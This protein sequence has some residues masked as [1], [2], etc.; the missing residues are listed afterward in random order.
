MMD[1][2]MSFSFPEGFHWG[3]ATAAHQ[4][5]GDNVNSDFWVMEHVEGTVF[6]EPS[7]H[8]CDHYHLYEQD[9]ARLADLGFNAY[10][11]SIEWARIEPEKGHFSTAQLD[12]YKR[13]IAVCRQ[14]G[15]TPFVTLQHFTSPRWLAALGGWERPSAADDFALY[16]EKVVQYLGEEVGAICTL[17]EIN[18]PLSMTLDRVLPGTDRIRSLDMV[19][20]AGAKLGSDCFSAFFFGDAVKTAATMMKAHRKAFDAIKNVQPDLPV[21]LTLALQELQFEP[22]GEEMWRERMR[23]VGDQFLEQC[24]GDDFIGVQT[25]TRT[26][27]DEN[28]KIP[29]PNDVEKTMMGYEYYPQ[30]LEQTIRWASKVSGCPVIVTENGIS[31]EDDDRRVAF[32]DRAL[33]SVQSCL[34]DGIDVEGYFYWSMLDNFEWMLGYRPKFGLIA[35]DRETQVRTVKPSAHHLGLIAST[36]RLK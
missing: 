11:F 19:K 12:H 35:V 1:E 32:I 6:K 34:E 25:Y 31:T 29:V 20:N 26:V 10:R 16:A 21:G 13:M 9:I 30:A 23:L 15:I 2:L 33:Q 27:F 28:G 8:A 18:I 36:N 7:G 24:R 14:Q 4:V 5:E 17:N 22:G 3:T